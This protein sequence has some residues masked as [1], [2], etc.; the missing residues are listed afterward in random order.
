V[1]PQKQ[2]TD[3]I[4]KK[5]NNSHKDAKR[6]MTTKYKRLFDT[7]KACLQKILIKQKNLMNY[8]LE[9]THTEKKTVRA[10]S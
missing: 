5:V 10:A 2:N 8:G 6:K 9:Q 3:D 7:K 1:F 4:G